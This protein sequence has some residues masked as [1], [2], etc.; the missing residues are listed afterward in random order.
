MAMATCVF[1]CMSW[2]CMSRITCFNIF[3]GSSA[4]SIRSLR[5][6]RTRVETLSNSAIRN[7]AFRCQLPVASCQFSVL[8]RMLLFV[9]FEPG[10]DRAID[11]DDAERDRGH[12]QLARDN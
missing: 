7:L 3:S 5:F 12:R 1:T 6:A 8:R 9:P 10:D 4:L 2:F 11:D